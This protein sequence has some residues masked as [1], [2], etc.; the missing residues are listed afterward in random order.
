M[1]YVVT[2]AAGF[3]GSNLVRALNR[4]GE[5]RVVAVDNLTRGDKFRNLAPCVVADYF[6]KSEFLAAISGDSLDLPIAAVFHQGACSDTVE[7]DG[8]YMMQNNYRYTVTLLD[9]CQEHDVPLIYAS[10]AAVYGSGPR[11]QEHPSCERPLNVYGYSKL[12]FDQHLRLRR[13]DLTA[14]VVGLRYFNVYG[15]GEA[16][17]GRM[18]SVAFHL[19]HQLRSN[20]RVRLFKGGDG[21]GDGEQRRDFVHVDDVVRANLHFLDHPEVTGIYNV[22]TGIARPFNDVAL[23]VVNAVGASRGESALSLDEARARGIIEYIDFPKELQGKYQSFTEADLT[24][25][26]GSGYGV[27]F[28]D[29]EE[30]VSAYVG[31]MLETS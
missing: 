26:R 6:D 2:G 11:F 29:V 13:D 31:A 7:S 30:G 16:H 22:G 23:A 8:R 21:Y 18:A 1:Y 17:K 9:W 10:S 25:L 28:A 19:F 4:R 3:V 5:H 14:P 27:P 12:A 15:P 24:G 20:G